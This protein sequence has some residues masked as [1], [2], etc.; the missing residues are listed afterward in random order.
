MVQCSK[1]HCHWWDARVGLDVVVASLAL[2]L[3]W[4][5]LTIALPQLNH[6]KKIIDKSLRF[7]SFHY[8]VTYRCFLSRAGLLS[9]SRTQCMLRFVR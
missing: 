6:K 3:A 7:C 4:V 8:V 5:S 2:H 1:Q 9:T